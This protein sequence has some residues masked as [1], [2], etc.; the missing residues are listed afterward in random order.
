MC[1]KGID[2]FDGLVAACLAGIFDALAV[3]CGKS[4]NLRCART[5]WRE[6]S[7]HSRC[8]A[9][10]FDALA[11]FGGNFRCTSRCL[12][13]TFDALVLF[14][15][16][17]RCTGRLRAGLFDAVALFLTEMSMQR[18]RASA[19]IFFSMDSLR[20]A[21]DG[22]IDNIDFFQNPNIGSMQRPRVTT[23]KHHVRQP[24]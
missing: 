11:L 17:F 9:G 1:E 18:T 19:L 14:G 4:W 8:L 13:G 21:R 16:N 7:M 12:A 10:T 23:L 22:I 2:G 5:V 15:G 24:R 20:G 6:V 3:F